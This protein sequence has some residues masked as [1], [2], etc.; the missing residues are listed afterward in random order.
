MLGRVAHDAAFADLSFTDLE[1][2]LHEDHERPGADVWR[3]EYSYHCRQNQCC[4][5]ETDVANREVD[6]LPQIREFNIP[7]IDPFMHDDAGVVAQSPVELAR[8]DIDRVN[9]GGSGL[10]EAIGESAG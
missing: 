5:Y 4:R 3:Y 1:L 9:A 10:E 8:P 2:R 7:G 6:W